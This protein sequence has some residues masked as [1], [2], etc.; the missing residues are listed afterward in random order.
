MWQVAKETREC[1]VGEQTASRV[2]QACR[3]LRVKM[4]RESFFPHF[5]LGIAEVEFELRGKQILVRGK[6]GI[7]GHGKAC[8]RRRWTDGSK[9]YTG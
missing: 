3:T 5:S 2:V 8:G 1:S 9:K 6:A 4:H 7:Q